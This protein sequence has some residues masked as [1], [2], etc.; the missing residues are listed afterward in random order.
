M[1]EDYRNPLKNQYIHIVLYCIYSFLFFIKNQKIF[2]LSLVLQSQRASC[3]SKHAWEM[4]MMAAKAKW[5]MF[6]PIL[7]GVELHECS[8]FNQY[9]IKV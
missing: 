2:L 1:A 4:V 7:N 9:I 5:T 8:H 6:D 3:F